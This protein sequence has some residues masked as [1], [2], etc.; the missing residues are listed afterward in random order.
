[1]SKKENPL[2]Y[3]I[4]NYT[5]CFDKFFFHWIAR[6]QRISAKIK[7]LVKTQSIIKVKLKETEI[8]WDFR[9]IHTVYISNT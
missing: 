3:W 2:K 6:V 8:A 4:Y 5:L 9:K 7:T 1:M